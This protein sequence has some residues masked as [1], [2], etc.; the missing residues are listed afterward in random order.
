MTPNPRPSGHDDE[1]SISQR[2]TK[3]R[4]LHRIGT[5]LR[6]DTDNALVL[7][8]SPDGDFLVKLDHFCRLLIQPSV[9]IRIKD[10]RVYL[11]EPSAHSG[12]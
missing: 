2:A 7:T 3:T 11:K 8:A 5:I 9:K 6:I 12:R 10:H 4:M 1:S